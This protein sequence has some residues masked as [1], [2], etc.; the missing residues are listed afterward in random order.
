LQFLQIFDQINAVLVSRR[1]FS[2]TSSVHGGSSFA[3]VTQP[4]PAERVCSDILT[5]EHKAH[6]LLYT[7]S[8]GAWRT[9]GFTLHKHTHSCDISWGLTL[10]MWSNTQAKWRRKTTLTQTQSSDVRLKVS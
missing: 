2:L 8:T 6:C 1:D 7:V 3:P 9:R 10:G 5:W 4:T